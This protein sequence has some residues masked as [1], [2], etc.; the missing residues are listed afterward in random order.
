MC[1]ALDQSLCPKRGGAI[2]M[3]SLSHVLSYVQ[4]ALHLLD[5]HSKVGEGQCPI[6]KA[7][8]QIKTMSIS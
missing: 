2:G 3:V 4:L 6:G 1:E 7:I 5:P 8:L